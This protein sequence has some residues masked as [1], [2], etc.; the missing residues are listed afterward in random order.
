[1]EGEASILH[2][3]LDAFFAA[4]EQRDDPRLRGRPMVVGGGVVLAAS[5]EAR[6]Y[7]IRGAMGGREARRRCPHLIVVPPRFK[8]YVEASEAVFGVFRDATPVVEGVS[9]DEAF[10]HVGGLRHIVGPPVEV[11]RRLRGDV[12]ERTGL[13]ITVGVARTK[14]LAKVA[15]GVA[16]PDGLLLV[17]PDREREFLDPLRVGQLWGV[18][19]ASSAALGRLGFRT[20][21]DVADLRESALVA[22]LG[23]GSGRRVHALVHNRDP[24][25]V[26]PGRRRRSV[27]SQSALGRPITDP[28]ELD[29]ILVAVVDRVT[30]RMRAGE[31]EG[32][33]VVLR[34][35]FGDFAKATRSRTLPRP[36]AQ[37]ATV[38]GA[39]RRLLHS[40]GPLVEERG[41]TLIGLAMTNLDPGAAVQLE[42]PVD[43]HDSYALDA[44]VDTIRDKFGSSALTRAVLLRRGAFDDEAEGLLS[45]LVTVQH[46]PAA[47]T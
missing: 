41:L 3:D 32:R 45:R 28:D 9:I 40:V 21:A 7:G 42:L 20:V 29:P 6:A 12:R 5:Y 25:P 13:T 16:K 26:V 11:A 47:T 17:P 4:V 34:L 19:P 44:S 39:A 38:L 22:I 2:A 15:S 8:A 10:L 46:D 33:T 35:R 31:H 36:T 37:T 1:M 30:R 14:F 24:R 18:G 43:P 27:G 23:R